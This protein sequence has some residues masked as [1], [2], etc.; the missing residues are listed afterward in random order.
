MFLDAVVVCNYK[1]A[2]H[3]ESCGFGF[4]NTDIFFPTIVDLVRYYTRYSLKK[5]NQHL[6][7]RLRIPIFRGTI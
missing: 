5:H 7:T 1:D 3:P 2:K 4:H 6:D